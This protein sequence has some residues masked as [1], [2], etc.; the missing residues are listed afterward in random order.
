MNCMHTVDDGASLVD[1]HS[2][3]G[4]VCI[5]VANC[6]NCKNVIFDWTSAWLARGV[7]VRPCL[8]TG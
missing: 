1:H 5:P 4:T 8:L 6:H 7:T 2:F 3:F